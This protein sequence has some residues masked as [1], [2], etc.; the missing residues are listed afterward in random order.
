M[1]IRGKS[2]NLELQ[3]LELEQH[4]LVPDIRWKVKLIVHNS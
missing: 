4:V 1:N 2:V 3:L